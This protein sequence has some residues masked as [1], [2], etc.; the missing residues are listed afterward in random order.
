MAVNINIP[1]QVSQTITNGVTAFAPSEDAV[2]DALALKQ[3]TLTNPV[4]GTGANGQVS[5]WTGTGAQSGDNGLFWDNV[6]KRLGVGTNVPQNTLTVGGIIRVNLSTTASS[7]F[8]PYVSGAFIDSLKIVSNNNAATFG[9]HNLNSSGFS[10]IEYL[11]NLGQPR[12]FTG[13]NNNNGTEFRFNNFASNGFIDFLIS[14]T[15]A[16]R[17]F[18]AR[19]IGINQ[20]TDAGFRLDVNGTARVQGALDIGTS[21]TAST[22]TLPQTSGWT[23]VVIPNNATANTGIRIRNTAG[24]RSITI[25]GINLDITLG[26]GGRV[27]SPTASIGG[28]TFNGS[29]TVLGFNNAPFTLSDTTVLGSRTTTQSIVM[30]RPGSSGAN[31][32]NVQVVANGITPVTIFQAALQVDS[33]NQ[34]FLPPRLTTTQ[35]NNITTPPAGLIVYDNTLNQLSYYDGTIWINV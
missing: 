8:E 23:D 1:T 28:F 35:K 26:P 15:S 17:I 7:T 32:G 21:A 22:I 5:F 14:N 18:N 19:N 6:N 10:G 20:T 31:H 30:L 27:T 11:N 9:I 13:F 12:V 2:F 29:A 25:G 4:T 34:G 33:P 16:F 24:S 3:D